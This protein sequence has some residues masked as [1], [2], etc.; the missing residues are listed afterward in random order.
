M[1]LFWGVDLK[2]AFIFKI[3]QICPGTDVSD[4]VV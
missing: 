2:Y 1:L 4:L 3:T